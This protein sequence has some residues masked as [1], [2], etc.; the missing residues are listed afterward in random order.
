MAKNVRERMIGGAASLLSSRGLEGTSFAEVLEA[1]GAP[2][3][4]VYHHF[5]GGKAE[6]VGEAVRLAG[7]RFVAGLER[8]GPATPVQA[9]DAI[10]SGWRSLL[11]RSTCTAGCAVAA[12]TVVGASDETLRHEAAE[13]FATWTTRLTRVFTRAGLDRASARALATTTLAAIE[14][15][16]I[17][18]RAQGS[19][20][21]FDVVAKQLRRM[22]ETATPT[23]AP[24]GR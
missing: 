18:S 20:E 19:I 8:L 13:V 5:P 3:G 2:R 16:L 1:T 7:A 10:T 15:A 12:V 9:M 22:A 6:L 14:G 24:P 4:S 21:P 23:P 11:T 17:L